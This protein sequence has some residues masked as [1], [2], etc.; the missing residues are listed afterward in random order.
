MFPA[1]DARFRTTRVALSLSAGAVTIRA[2]ECGDPASASVA[3]CVHGWACTVYS[4]RRLMPLLGALGMRACA[5]DLPGH[6]LSDKPHDPR[7]YTLDSQAECVLAAMDALGISRAV[8][9]GHSMGGPI[10][11]RAAVLAP[12]RV[13]ALALLA[14]AGFGTEWDLRILRLITPRALTPA[15]PRLFRR[16]MVALV[17]RS[18]YGPRYMPSERDVD[19]YWAPSQFPGF[20]RAM[21]ELLH[22]FEWN[23]GADGGFAS[24]VAPTVILDGRRDNFV[25]RR[26]VASYGTVLSNARFIVV[27]DCGHVVP[28]EVPDLVA[29]AIRVLIG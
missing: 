18:A 24:I 22:C 25:V 15:L 2:V 9:V 13:A 28:E 7:L 12:E 19:E 23:A 29:R 20:V 10:C 27:D 1:G 11:A 3:V 16:W 26:W 17:L 8:L 4:F 14:P 21:W 6:G 5:I